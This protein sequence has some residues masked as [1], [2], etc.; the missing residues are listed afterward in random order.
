MSAYHGRNALKSPPCLSSRLAAKNKVRFPPFADD[1]FRAPAISY[2]KIQDDIEAL[3]GPNYLSTGLLDY[4]L[5]QVLPKDLPNDVL[6]GTSNS[7]SYFET[8]NKKNINS[9]NQSEATSAQNL[10]RKYQVYS[11]RRYRFIAIHCLK[12]HF[13]V[14]SA[15]FDMENAEDILYE[16]QV[17]DSLRKST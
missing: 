9:N 16:V 12:G 6:I 1:P 13:S 3:N 10:R 8:E 15:V 5:Q 17:F 7:F 14:I 11:F 4:L 2:D